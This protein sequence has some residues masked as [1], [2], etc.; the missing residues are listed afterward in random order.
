[1]SERSAQ[2]V[3][4]R[5]EGIGV[6]VTGPSGSGKSRLALE[7]LAR[8]HALVADDLVLLAR[9]GDRLRGRAEAALAG[10]LAVREAG[11][12]NVQRLFGD[13]AWCPEHT[14][15]LVLEPGAGAEPFGPELPRREIAGVALPLM[16]SHDTARA[17]VLVETVCR[18]LALRRDGYDAAADLEQRQAALLHP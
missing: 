16:R 7:L 6:L 3:L 8:G 9:D 1:M 14:I 11:V 15:D 2:G 4:L 10:F 12:F 17:A 13:D 5:V 18:D